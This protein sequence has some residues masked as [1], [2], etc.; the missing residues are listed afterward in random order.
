MVGTAEPVDPQRVEVDI[1]IV[2]DGE[3]RMTGEGDDRFDAGAP[4]GDHVVAPVD[5]W[6][7]PG[8]A[9]RNAA[10]TACSLTS[11]VRPVAAWR[12]RA[13]SSGW[14]MSITSAIVA[15][16]SARRA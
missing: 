13:R 11:S 3:Q 14:S 4:R 16:I 1:V 12:R 10:P 7:R 15:G 6:E 2:I 9:A 8:H 5:G